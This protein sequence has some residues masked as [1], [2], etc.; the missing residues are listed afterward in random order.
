MKNLFYTIFIFFWIA[1][2]V[3]SPNFLLKSA[4]FFSPPYSFYVVVERV[5][6]T[7]TPELLK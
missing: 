6:T 7:Y 1:G 3:L 5:I 2:I 4:S